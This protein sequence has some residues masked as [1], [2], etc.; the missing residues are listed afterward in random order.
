MREATLFLDLDG[1]FADFEAGFERAF[2]YKRESCLSKK[3]FWGNINGRKDFFFDLDVIPGAQQFLAEL[4]RIS[5][6]AYPNIVFL[7]GGSTDSFVS[8]AQQKL[9]WVREKLQS[10]HPVYCAPGGRNKAG[11]K[12]QRQDLLLDDTAQ[13]LRYWAEGGGYCIQ[14]EYKNFSKSLEKLNTIVKVLGITSHPK[15]SKLYYL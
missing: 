12:Q 13:N 8:I 7:S 10:S 15:V 1:V 11:F 4:E 2:G 3:E 9:R 5:A 14:H 6:P